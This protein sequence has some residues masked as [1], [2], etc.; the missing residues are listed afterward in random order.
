[1]GCNINH[2][3]HQI[4]VG[5]R[6]GYGYMIYILVSDEIN[7]HS[8][9]GGVFPTQYAPQLYLLLDCSNQWD[10][11]PNRVAYLLKYEV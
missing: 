8:G 9:A 7:K 1:M 6:K 2:S 5:V 10:G 11:T 4:L 3:Q